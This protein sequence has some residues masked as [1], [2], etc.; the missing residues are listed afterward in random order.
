MTV[1]EGSQ[2]TLICNYTGSSIQSL[3]WMKDD[4]GAIQSPTQIA[5][6]IYHIG[7]EP[8]YHNGYN[9]STYT[10][11]IDWHTNTFNLLIHSVDVA[12]D[13][14]TFWC[15]ARYWVGTLII[16]SIDLTVIVLPKTIALSDSSTSYPS[17]DGTAY[18]L[19]GMDHRFTCE[20][21]DINPGASFTWSLGDATITPYNTVNV[22]GAD[23]L[24][25]STSMA[26]FSP[27]W[28]H[29]GK[30][31]RC[32]ASNDEEYEGI[33][34]NIRLYVIGP[35]ETPVITGSTSM[36]ENEA[37]LLTC[38]ADMGYPDDWTLV[39][40][41]GG[42][43]GPTTSLSESGD[44]YS[45]TSTLDY[46]PRRQDNGN[47]ITCTANRAPW[48]PGPVGSLGPI[49]VK[50]EVNITNKAMNEVRV[51]D[52]E[53]AVLI[54][55]A[56]GNPQPL[57]E[58][59]CTNNTMITS[60]VDEGKFPVTHE[61]SGGDGIFEFKVTSKLTVKA[62][63]S[64][65]DYG[66]YTCISSNGIGR[67]DSLN[68]TLTEI[69]TNVPPTT[70]VPDD[71]T[72]VI[73]GIIIG[74]VVLTVIAL[75]V[76][77]TRRSRKASGELDCI[78][79]PANKKPGTVDYAN[80][81]T[82][83][84]AFPRDQ[85]KIIK[86][87]GHGA[88]GQVLLAEASGMTQGSKVTLVAV[89]TLKD[90]AGNSEKADLMRELD[91]M[92][93][94]PDHCNVVRLLGFCVEEDPPYIIVEY[95]SRGNLKDLLKDSRS[96]GRRVYGNL[97]GI[98]KSLTSKDLMKFAKDVAD[99]MAF[100]SSQRCIHRDLAARNVLVAEDM[101]CKVADFGLARDVM[102]IRVYERRSQGP[103]P[104]RWMAFESI[105]DDVYTTESDVWSYGVLLWEIVTLGA[106]PY[107]AMTAKIMVN[108]LQSG[109]R[110]PKP[111]H[112][113][114]E[115]YVM[116]LR[117]WYEDP[118]SRPTFKMI[119]KELDKLITKEKEYI[120]LDDFEESIYEVALKDDA[121]EKV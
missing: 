95:Q 29:H 46:T 74:F 119:S 23:K 44:R 37:T 73:I 69:M 70:T 14:G 15:F 28:S 76:Y 58:W 99:G 2:A 81:P 51:K 13:G 98:S 19:K 38:T 18:L 65:V 82:A 48:I 60:D 109:Y 3:E 97:H 102:N 55:I 68:I 77:V 115:L 93:K 39:W 87:L 17:A 50:Y 120:S 8:I 86:E 94:L 9:S 7:N 25:T 72:V 67:E 103:L 61:T 36:T 104:M 113:Q 108:E 78:S 62:V 117:C 91:L 27:T 90:G 105:L 47:I 92:K 4:D 24:T 12:A 79:Q 42:S 114:E 89:K 26:T 59:Y 106:R 11:S 84:K 100:I 31:L 101:T 30:T 56:V 21:P 40:S 52:G 63:D 45:F 1:Y 57:M 10:A 35:T 71:K 49:D 121:G 20:V 75:G 6:I 111:L 64:Q 53:N 110:M 118:D 43:P 66:V 116:M 88:F 33:S 54:C 96:K 112:C 16:S 32:Q 85:L 83:H 5:E 41:N 80:V 34:V 22:T 107:P